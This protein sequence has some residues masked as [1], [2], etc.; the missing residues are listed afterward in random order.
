MPSAGSRQPPPFR[1]RGRRGLRP[2]ARQCIFRRRV[3]HAARA[4]NRGGDVRV[5]KLVAVLLLCAASAEAQL[6]PPAVPLITHD[7]YFSVWSAGDTLHSE[8]TRHWTGT[9]QSLYSAVRVDGTLYRLM[10]REVRG[11]Q[12]PVLSQQSLTVL[13]TRT[14]YKFA[15]A[16]V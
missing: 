16:G 13:P 4:S 11:P 5:V 10:G 8:Q 14:I 1:R 7:P 2:A 6:R 12:G 9:V 15:G 3:R